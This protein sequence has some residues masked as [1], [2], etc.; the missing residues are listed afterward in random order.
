M[1]ANRPY[2]V[3][4]S[5]VRFLN[6]ST[7]ADAA[8]AQA[9]GISQG[10][11]GVGRYA[12]DIHLDTGGHGPD[13]GPVRAIR[14]AAVSVTKKILS[15]TGWQEPTQLVGRA[16]RKN[17]ASMLERDNGRTSNWRSNDKVV[18]LLHMA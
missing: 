18:R 12:A 5:N 13:Q 17:I 15:K 8:R 6:N 7:L 2:S 16:N 3:V 10:S 11:V 14:N 4:G 9:C 1:L